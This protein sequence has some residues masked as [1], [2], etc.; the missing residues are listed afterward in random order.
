MPNLKTFWSSLWSQPSGFY[1]KLQPSSANRPCSLCREQS[2]HCNAL[3][4]FLRNKV[5]WKCSFI[6]FTTVF[7]EAQNWLLPNISRFFFHFPSPNGSHT[8]AELIDYWFLESLLFSLT[9]PIGSVCLSLTVL[10][11]PLV[12]WVSLSESLVTKRGSKPT[13]SNQHS[14]YTHIWM[15]PS[16][17]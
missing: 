12:T 5:T 1:Q 9:D 15:S 6:S 10:K 8:F 7:R 13:K 2:R 3:G 11:L 17:L 4:W 14:F 16:T